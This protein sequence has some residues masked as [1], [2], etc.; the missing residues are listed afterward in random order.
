M[1]ARP[2]PEKFLVA[3]SLAGEQRDLVRGIAEAVERELGSG[4]VFFDEWF[5]A[6]LGGDDADLKLQEIYGKKCELAVFCV[7]GRYGD[8]PWTQ[9]EHRAIRARF[10]KATESADRRER[11]TVFP[12]RVGDGEVEGILFNAIVPDIRGRSLADRAQLVLDR[13]RLIIPDL[14]PDGGSP[15]S[16]PEWPENPPPLSWPMADHSGARKAFAEL[17]TSNVRWRFLPIRG[18]SETGKSHITRQMLANTLAIPDIACG[19][20]DFKGTTGMDM[21]VSAFVQDLGVGVPSPNSRLPE[22]LGQILGAIK[23]RARPTLLIFDTYE[24]AGEAQE[25]VEKQL[26][27]TLIRATWMRV[28]ICGQKVPDPTSAVAAAHPTVHLVPPLP[29]DWFDYGRQH[30][31]DL[32]LPKVEAACDLADH[33]A[34]L[35]AQLLGPRA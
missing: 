4:T 29:A 8:K 9:A 17:L 15:P 26:L 28:V 13:L 12:I 14:R 20:F 16:G 34:S 18:P 25:W 22:R 33:K 30:R 5:E 7:S 6:Y 35:L 1:S 21:E 3:F 19:R 10:M 31:P 24:M 2:L 11:L 27:P 32:T 23:E